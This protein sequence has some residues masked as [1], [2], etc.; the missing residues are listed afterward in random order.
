MSREKKMPV[1]SKKSKRKVKKIRKVIDENS[2]R[3][4]IPT[5]RSIDAQ[6]QERLKD[7][8]E[9]AYTRAERHVAKTLSDFSNSSGSHV[10]N[11]MSGQSNTRPYQFVATPLFSSIYPAGGLQYLHQAYLQR[12]M[13]GPDPN[14]ARVPTVGGVYRLPPPDSLPIGARIVTPLTDPY[15]IQ[16]APGRPATFQRVSEGFAPV[17][18]PSALTP[19]LPYRAPIMLNKTRFTN[20][21]GGPSSAPAPSS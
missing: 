18:F 11:D 5:K 8:Q 10:A 16:S 20:R 14:K 4:L 3:P 7:E 13:P 19:R 15:S 21:P 6:I 9:S 12:M 17:S 2:S 1:K